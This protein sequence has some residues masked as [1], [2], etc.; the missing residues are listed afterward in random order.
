[1]SIKSFLRWFVGDTDGP[2]GPESER[3]LFNHFNRP[4]SLPWPPADGPIVGNR[5]KQFRPPVDPSS[6][7]VPC[8]AHLCGTDIGFCGLCGL[9]GAVTKEIADTYWKSL[10]DRYPASGQFRVSAKHPVTGDRASVTI[11]NY[12]PEPAELKPTVGYFTDASGPIAPP[13]Q[14]PYAVRPRVVA[15]ALDNPNIPMEVHEYIVHLETHFARL[16]HHGE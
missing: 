8:P 3:G 1:M 6:E 9:E 5:P 2:L 13:R 11:T 12:A 14:V 4:E 15:A 7:M 16:A 10:A